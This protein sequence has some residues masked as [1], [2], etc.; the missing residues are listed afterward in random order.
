MNLYR[1]IENCRLCGSPNLT[2]VMSLGSQHLASN[3]VRSN[4]GHPLAEIR[5]PLTV[6]LCRNC[7]MLQLKETVDRTILYQDYFYRSGTNPIMRDA[8]GSLVEDVLAHVEVQAGD[9][10]L[11]IGCNDCTMLSAFPSKLER[12]GVD[13]AKNINWSRVDPSIRI[14][15]DFFS[16]ESVLEASRGELFKIVASV[17]MFYALDN[18]NAMAAEVKSILAPDGVWCIQVSYLPELIRNLNFYDVCHEHLLYFSLR[19]LSDLMEHNGLVIVDA[20]T[21]ELN[22][23]SL[24]VFVA[25]KENVQQRSPRVQ[26]LLDI[27][28]ASGLANADTYREFF[29]KVTTLKRKVTAYLRKEKEEGHLVIGLG[30]S[31]KGNVLLQLFGIDKEVLPY[32]SERNPEKVALRTLGTDIELISEE[33]ARALNPSCMLVLIWFFKEEVLRRERAYLERGGT[34]LFPMPYGHLVSKEDEWKL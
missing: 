32:I 29:D 18:P 20:S 15:N 21:S 8:L 14:I 25:H 23:G 28:S 34:L 5:I 10:V 1:T 11:D 2:D 9:R 6:M 30:A 27:E 12:I 33:R 13:P 19:T 3:F 26:R 22:G 4:E 24:R 16:R 31:T 7:S 17:A